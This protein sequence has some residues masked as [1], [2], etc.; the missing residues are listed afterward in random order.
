MHPPSDREDVGEDVELA[1]KFKFENQSRPCLCYEGVRG[2]RRY[3]ATDFQTSHYI[4]VVRFMTRAIYLR[5]KGSPSHTV[6]TGWSPQ[7]GL[8]FGE[9]ENRLPLP[10]FEPQMALPV[11]YSLYWLGYP[12]FCYYVVRENFNPNIR[13][14]GSERDE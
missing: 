5:K 3:S 10:G 14:E 9:Q 11:A 8:A 2:K 6:L 12:V 1:L 13:S 7:P 4:G